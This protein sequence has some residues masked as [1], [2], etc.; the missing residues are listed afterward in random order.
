V[1]VERQRMNEKPFENRCRTAA[2]KIR[3]LFPNL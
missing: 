2:A 1:I 3:T